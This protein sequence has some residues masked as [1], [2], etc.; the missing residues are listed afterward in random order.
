MGGHGPLVAFLITAS[1]LLSI[2]T[3][4]LWLLLAA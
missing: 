1:T 2:L 4:P 3:L